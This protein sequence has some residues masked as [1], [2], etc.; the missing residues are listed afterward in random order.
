MSS[1]AFITMGIR[2]LSIGAFA[3][4]ALL[5]NPAEAATT[6]QA[7]WASVNKHIVA[8]EWFMDAKFGIYYH[9]GAFCTPQYGMEWYPRNMYNKAGNSNEYK[10]H[11]ATYGDPFGDWQYHN[12]ILGKNN[13]AGVFTQFAPKLK[14]A[15]GKFD[16]DEWARLFDSAGAKFA[17]PV[18]EHHDGFSMWDSKANEWNSVAK[19]PK[20]DLA[21]LHATAIRARGLKFM[22]SMHHAW[23]FTGYWNFP[24]VTQTDASLKK[25]Y[26]QMTTAE[27]E[28]LWIDKLKEVID[29]YQPDLIWQDLYLGR[30]SEA[31][32][33]EF[34]SYYYNKSVD[35]NKDVVVTSK[36]GFQKGEMR[37][38]E[39]G[40]PAD[41]TTPYWLTDDAINSNSWSYVS[42]MSYY[43]KTQMLH[44]LIDRVSKNG[45]LLL[46]I[47][48]M[49]DGSIPQAQRDLLLAMGDWLRRFGSSI[50]A[51]RVWSIY[52]EGPTKMGGGSFTAPVAGTANDIRYTRAKDTS[53]VY[54]IFLGW[55]GNGVKKAL[56][57]LNSSRLKLTSGVKVQLMGATPGTDVDLVYSQDANGLN[58]TFPS[59]APYSALAY[60]VRVQLKA[61]SG[62]ESAEAR[63]ATG[64]G[65]AFSING[66]SK[67]AVPDGARWVTVMDVRGHV[68]DRRNLSVADKEFAPIGH[69]AALVRFDP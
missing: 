15:G 48:P 44:S 52:G 65:R 35:W 29:G 69:G 33:L 12:F 1:R 53:A 3:A 16:P 24:P 63:P 54:A 7:T 60:P 47:S 17:G 2:G 5:G 55:P 4:V 56:T 58:V 43:S 36:D 45:N 67:L 6:Y 62:L 42:G 30:I 21:K 26:G 27:E 25:L 11:L 59:S 32:R 8:P 40:G 50:Y 13:K 20:L 37:D 23:N 57:G 14:S 10:H 18:A 19:G 46:N 31:K 22:M 64:L 28:K 61:L 38:Y 9:W 68:L 41:I 66:L 49:A 34:L 39:R 51:T